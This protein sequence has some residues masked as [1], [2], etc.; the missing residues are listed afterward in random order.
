MESLKKNSKYNKIRFLPNDYF[1]I[2]G[3]ILIKIYFFKL[4]FRQN[5]KINTL[6]KHFNS[7]QILMKKAYFIRKM[8]QMPNDMF[9]RSW[10]QIFFK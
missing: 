10:M 3:K 4:F 6:T 7:K 8:I 9:S 1:E 5:F 2:K